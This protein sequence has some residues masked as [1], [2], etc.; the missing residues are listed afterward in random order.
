MDGQILL[1]D[2]R[3]TVPRGPAALKLHASTMIPIRSL[4]WCPNGSSDIYKLAVQCDRCIRLY[5]IRRT[6]KTL[7]SSID[8]EH[9]Q[10]IIGMDWTTQNRSVFTL[11]NDQSIRA[12]APSG[13][14]LAESMW[15][16]S[17]YVT[18]KVCS[19]DIDTIAFLVS[20]Y[21]YLVMCNNV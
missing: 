16:E 21:R 14:L 8:L 7:P 17:S 19:I 6:D 1:W 5:D 11:S 15:S 2:I 13:Q 18:T 3:C 20:L 9:T 4:Q 12:Y 10:R